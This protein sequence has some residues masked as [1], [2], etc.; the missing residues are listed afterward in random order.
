MRPKRSFIFQCDKDQSI[1]F[2]HFRINATLITRFVFV[3][4]RLNQPVNA[5]TTLQHGIL[6][7]GQAK[8]NEWPD[9]ND[10]AAVCKKKKQKTKIQYRIDDDELM[11]LMMI[12]GLMIHHDQ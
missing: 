3:Q 2:I 6:K 11:M 8:K 4:H 7:E 12:M 10:N 5:L 9:K 1:Y